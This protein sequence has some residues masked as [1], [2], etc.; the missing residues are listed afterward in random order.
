M[1]TIRFRTHV[2][3]DGL[4]KLEIPLEVADSDLEVE[5]NVQ[6]IEEAAVTKGTWP[7]G[8]FEQTAGVLADDPL[9]RASQGEY[10][11]REPLQ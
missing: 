7:R 10:E 9:I 1:Q 11:K 3:T 6:P 4:L 5:I 8:Y 2:G